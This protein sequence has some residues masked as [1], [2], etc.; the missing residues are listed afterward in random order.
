MADFLTPGLDTSDNPVSGE[1]LRNSM[2]AILNDIA[3]LRRCGFGDTVT[4]VAGYLQAYDAGSG[5]IAFRVV[6]ADGTT[7][8]EALAGE[9]ILRQDLDCNKKALLLPK[10]GAVAQAS[11]EPIADG[12]FAVLQIETETGRI[13]VGADSGG[14]R[15]VLGRFD[16]AGSSYVPIECVIDTAGLANPAGTSTID[17][18]PGWVLDD[19]ND[20][21]RIN[22]KQPIPEGW[23]AAHD[24]LIELLVKLG[25]AESV[26]DNID[27]RAFFKTALIGSGG[28]SGSATTANSGQPNMTTGL[29]TGDFQRVT[30]AMPRADATNPTAVDAMVQAEIGRNGLTNVGSILVV[31]ARLLVPAHDAIAYQA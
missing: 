11:L 13:V 19:N 12:N 6:R 29:A 30:I 9:Y 5:K 15:Y 1:E 23:T 10:L 14:K 7:V 18:Q 26:G 28:H 17:G 31:S 4:K 27:A 2:L 22:A 25:Q 8:V 3:L 16:L 21:I 20:R 24:V